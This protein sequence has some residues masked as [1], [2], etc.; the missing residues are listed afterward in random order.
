MWIKFYAILSVKEFK[1]E[2]FK[3]IIIYGLLNK[4]SNI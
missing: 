3:C 2:S 4:D 1:Y